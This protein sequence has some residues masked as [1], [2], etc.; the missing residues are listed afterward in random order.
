[1]FEFYVSKR[2]ENSKVTHVIL[3]N[4][5]VFDPRSLHKVWKYSSCV[6]AKTKP[7]SILTTA[8]EYS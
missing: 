8:L 6:F 3:T 1:M 2:C 4:L 5:H 7:Q